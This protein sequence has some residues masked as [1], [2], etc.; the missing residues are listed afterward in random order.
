ML[1]GSEVKSLRNGE[2]TI[3]ESYA[4]IVEGEMFLVN[5]YIPMYQ[6]AGRFNHETHR[7]RKLLLHKRVIDRLGGHINNGGMSFV[8][9]VLYFKKD[10]LG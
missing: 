4:E 8:P 6:E 7:S 3:A 1:E 2:A 9:I 10:C 5:A